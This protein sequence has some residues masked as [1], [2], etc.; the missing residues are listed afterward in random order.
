M[1][2]ITRKRKIPCRLAGLVAIFLLLG[3]GY[4]HAGSRVDVAF[5][6]SSQARD[7]LGGNDGLKAY[8]ALIIA[9]ANK[10]FRD[11]GVE[12][13]IN[14]KGLKRVGRGSKG[15]TGKVLSKMDRRK[16]GFRKLDKWQRKYK[17]DLLCTLIEFDPAAGG[18]AYLPFDPLSK[19]E[20][21]YNSE[22]TAFSTVSVSNSDAETFAHEIGHNL[23]CHHFYNDQSS[24]TPKN[25]KKRKIPK[26]SFGNQ[27]LVPASDPMDPPTLY[28]TIMSYGGEPSG[29]FSSP[30]VSFGGV[31]T[32]VANQFDNARLIRKSMKNVAKYSKRNRG[33]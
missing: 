1:A 25:A 33:S 6:Y 2:T 26:Y 27:F 13:T 31:P 10:A 7:Y 15:S 11:S 20:I 8:Q 16:S 5:L 21:A 32:G 17:C 18:R 29:L 4:S 30:V 22:R 28:G 23:G 12:L 9:T 24:D 19:R 14:A 3:S